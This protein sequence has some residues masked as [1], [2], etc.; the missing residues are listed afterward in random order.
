[1]RRRP[2]P[3]DNAV[4]TGILDATRRLL[5][6]QSFDEISVADILGEA[7]VARGSFYFYFG[8]K[9]DVLAQLVRDA[10][11]TG[12]TASKSWLDH[13]GPTDRRQAVR[14]SIA[15]GARLWTEQAPVLRAVVETAH[16]D[17]EIAMLWRGLMAEFTAVTAARLQADRAAGAVTNNLDTQTLAA[18][19]TWLGER[20][21]YLAAVGLP[22]FNDQDKLIDALTHTWLAVLYGDTQST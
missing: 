20:L 15:D 7:G 14:Q 1:M 13:D 16:T 8:R 22:P 5:D 3:A 10:I 18:T 4:R 17:P 12:H 2:Q 19:L 21:Y 9:H 6:R 11:T